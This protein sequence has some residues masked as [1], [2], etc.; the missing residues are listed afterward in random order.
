MRSKGE[1]GQTIALLAQ[2]DL[3][4]SKAGKGTQ[5]RQPPS[6]FFKRLLG[7]F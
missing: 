4:K 3:E 6:K 2:L 5:S 7:V 1:G